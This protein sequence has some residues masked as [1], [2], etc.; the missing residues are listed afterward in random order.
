MIKS[1]K[2]LIRS[3]L[4]IVAVS[5][6]TSCSTIDQIKRD[7]KDIALDTANYKKL[8]GSYSNAIGLLGTL[9][10]RQS[11]PSSL[12]NEDSVVLNLKTINKKSIKLDFQSKGKIIRTAKLRGKYKDGYF[13]TSPKFSISLTPLFPILWGSGVY[14]LSIG[15]TR[16]NNLVYL[17]S[18]GGIAFFLVLPFFGSGGE[19][20]HEIQRELK[21]SD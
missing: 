11:L 1:E 2:Y 13:K 4:F 19:S 7:R 10:G 21:E 6:F 16:G 15:L 17:E 12:K 9:N 3:F 14:N 8:D 20:G 18:H 5:C